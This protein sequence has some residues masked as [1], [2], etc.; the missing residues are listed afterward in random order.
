MLRLRAGARAAASP[1]AA[2]PTATSSTA[3]SPAAL[4][5]AAV[6]LVALLTTTLLACRDLAPT[7]P[8]TAPRVPSQPLASVAAPNGINTVVPLTVPASNYPTAGAIS[9]FDLGT[10]APNAVVEIEVS[11]TISVT[12]HAACTISG[13][14]ATP[15]YAG[16]TAS[17]RYGVGSDGLG[18]L[19]VQLRVV[20]PDGS[21]DYITSRAKPDDTTRVYVIKRLP[22]GGRLQI[23]RNG[24]AGWSE[25]TLHNT[26]PWYAL[27][28]TQ[29]VRVR[30]LALVKPY[31]TPTVTS[32]PATMNMVLDWAHSP[33][34]NTDWYYVPGDTLAT[35]AF[36]NLNLNTLRCRTTATTC[37]SY[38]AG[39]G[40]WYVALGGPSLDW[41]IIAGDP[42]NTLPQYRAIV[43][44]PSTAVTRGQNAICTVGVEPAVA[45]KVIMVGALAAGE[46]GG[47]HWDTL[48]PNTNVAAGATYAIQGPAVLTST[49]YAKVE[50]QTT[51]IPIRLGYGKLSVAARSWP[52]FTVAGPPTVA[53]KD[54]VFMAFRGLQMLVPAA[55]GLPNG[56]ATAG[57]AHF[58]SL[59]MDAGTPLTVWDSLH[60]ETVTAGPNRGYTYATQAMLVQPSRIILS[61]M[62]VGATPFRAAQYAGTAADG[63]PLC[64]ADSVTA[65]LAI[66]ERHE[67]VPDANGQPSGNSHEGVL[68][69]LLASRHLEVDLER[70]V[71]FGWDSVTARSRAQQ[72]FAPL[73]QAI[74][75][76]QIQFDEDEYGPQPSGHLLWDWRDEGRFLGC[77]FRPVT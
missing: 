1:T 66:A 39:P 23:K 49:V 65:F 27:S 26:Y 20:N 19:S 38:V 58:T 15:Q 29:Q 75:S 64:P 67:G 41:V 54:T 25:D 24:I 30:E 74:K 16:R 22:L 51:G 11:G 76:A 69:S 47:P 46:T 5:R 63:R 42:T 50:I 77:Y 73:Q 21:F 31:A 61:P 60:F 17:P 59:P 44:C 6:L 37:S 35:P 40:R 28:G 52:T 8:G 32:L 34:T 71:G 72:T 53:Y 56:Y 33:V 62:F 57:G 4:S 9:F 13:C 45:F 48:P 3:A 70:L 68:R 14:P 36:A 55:D 12:K 7:A 43:T 10:F 18:V 2:S